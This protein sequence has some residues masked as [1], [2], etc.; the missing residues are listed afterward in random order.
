M[1]KLFWFALAVFTAAPLTLLAIGVSV[2]PITIS[3]ETV[4]GTEK[5][6]KFTVSNPSRE[7]GLFEVYPEEFE[8]NIT[9]I[10]SRF[11][12]ESGER[13]EVLI[14]VRQN[15][16]GTFKTSIAIEVKPLGELLLG[17]G[18]GVRL[19]FS[20]T[21]REPRGAGL[22]AGAFANRGVD[23]FVVAGGVLLALLA[24]KRDVASA[25][26]TLRRLIRRQSA[27]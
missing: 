21:V 1:K 19:P 11:L 17:V 25:V 7:V 6:V 22:L 13:R 9:L 4:S 3:L 24:Y 8:R 16:T 2:S 5:S 10:P 18:G 12:L 15:E 27:P 20:F 26:R 14:R 23:G